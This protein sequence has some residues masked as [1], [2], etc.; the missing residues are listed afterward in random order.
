M[1]SST[2]DYLKSV[3]DDCIGCGICTQVQA[4]CGQVYQLEFGDIAT[5]LLDAADAA[6]GEGREVVIDDIPDDIQEF[7]RAC[8]LCGRCTAHCPAEIEAGKVSSAARSF[9]LGASPE[10]KAEYRRYRCDL[11]DSMYSRVRAVQGV[12]RSESLSRSASNPF[13]PKPGKSLFFPGCTLGNNFPGLAEG[14]YEKLREQSIVDCI[15]SFCCGRPLFLLGL[16]DERERY[17]EALCQRIIDS[18]VERIVTVCPNCYYALRSVL[19]E[20]GLSDKVEIRDL[21]DILVERGY[22]F[23]PTEKNPYE[24][25]MIHDSCPDRK[26]GLIGNN[27]RKIFENI[28]VVEPEHSHIDSICCG[29]GGMASVY[30]QDIPQAAFGARVNEFFA[31]HARCLV[32]SCVTCA[33]TFKSSGAINCKHYLELF[34]DLDMD[35]EA[36]SSAFGRLFDPSDEFYVG[37]FD[38]DEPFFVE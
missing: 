35:M 18:G 17:N 5:R 11:D 23:E 15:T 31:S 9:V 22:R 21:C 33:S 13:S 28:E 12:S 20:H 14:V 6:K 4:P 30:K 32:T 8:M 38:V 19:A 1:N 7:S 27:L 25:I 34:F 2:L 24:K 16:P 10:I 3:A 37:K 29:S 26:E 36:M